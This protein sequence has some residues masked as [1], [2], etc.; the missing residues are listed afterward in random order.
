MHDSSPAHPPMAPA[1]W[2]ACISSCL[3][4]QA[5]GVMMKGVTAPSSLLIGTFRRGVPAARRSAASGPEPH[6]MASW[7]ATPPV[8]CTWPACGVSVGGCEAGCAGCRVQGAGCRV[9]GAGCRVQGAG[10]RVQGAGWCTITRPVMWTWPAWGARASHVCWC[11]DRRHWVRG[12]LWGVGCGVWGVGCGVWGWY[13]MS[14]AAAQEPQQHHTPT[15]GRYTGGELHISRSLHWQPHHQH[16][17][18]PPGGGT[19]WS[20]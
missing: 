1:T 12:W 3:R 19:P 16:H 15:R 4:V 13:T 5:P 17:R 8:M 6:R 2:L 7:V 9:Q 14:A 18:H 11:G 20:W 10:C